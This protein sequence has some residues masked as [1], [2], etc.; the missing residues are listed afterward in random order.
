VPVAN[1]FTANSLD[2]EYPLKPISPTGQD[3]AMEFG[4]RSGTEFES[5]ERYVF[6][7][8]EQYLTV[9]ATLTKALTYQLISNT[10]FYLDLQQSY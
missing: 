4:G 2:R 1:Y 8:L 7:M 5:Q 9:T 10:V 3:S 6:L